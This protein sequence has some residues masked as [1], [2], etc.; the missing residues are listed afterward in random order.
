MQI[1]SISVGAALVLASVVASVSA[2]GGG[3]AT[4]NS[5][6]PIEPNSQDDCLKRG[7]QPIRNNSFNSA[8]EVL[9]NSSIFGER[10]DYTALVRCFAAKGIDYFVVAGPRAETASNHMNAIKDAF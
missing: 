4:T 5:W 1:R 10:G 9:G 8:F 7:A 3:P 6:L 2:Q